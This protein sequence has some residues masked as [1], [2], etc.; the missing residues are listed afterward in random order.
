MFNLVSIV[1]R[2]LAAAVN[3][4]HKPATTAPHPPPRLLWGARTQP[5]SRAQH[6]R[7]RNAV[8][9][10][11][12]GALAAPVRYSPL[13]HRHRFHSYRDASGELMLVCGCAALLDIYPD[14]RQIV[15][16][17]HYGCCIVRYRAPMLGVDGWPVLTR[18]VSEIVMQHE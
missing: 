6:R 18:P 4:W 8:H 7:A 16:E 2:N 5:C 12:M 1:R 9:A 10:L 11:N 14:G 15:T 13:E 3:H 17:Y